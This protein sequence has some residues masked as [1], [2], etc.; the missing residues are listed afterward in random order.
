MGESIGW[1][2][3]IR[4]S[5]KGFFDIDLSKYARPYSGYGLYR[6]QGMVKEASATK[7]ETVRGVWKE[8][9]GDRPFTGKSD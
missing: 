3:R 2:K 8:S 4:F 6:F 5:E 7:N 9:T 1:Y